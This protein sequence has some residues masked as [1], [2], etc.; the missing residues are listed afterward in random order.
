MAADTASLPSAPPDRYKSPTP[1]HPRM[2]RPS[3]GLR[4]L[5]GP[6]LA[7]VEGDT[8]GMSVEGREGDVRPT[9]EMVEGDVGTP[10]NRLVG[11]LRSPNSPCAAQ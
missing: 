11:V 6:S 5:R 3:G 9:F 2:R 7:T 1:V 4:H 8:V 10:A